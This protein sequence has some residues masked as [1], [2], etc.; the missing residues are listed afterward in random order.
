MEPALRFGNSRGEAG[1][2]QVLLAGGFQLPGSMRRLPFG[3][4][5]NMY[6]SFWT[7]ALRAQGCGRPLLPA[8]EEPGA[9]SDSAGLWACH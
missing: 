5:R 1:P 2:L 7:G 8:C 9:V 6:P 3:S 4:V